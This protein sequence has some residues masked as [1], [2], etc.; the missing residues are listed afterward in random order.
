MSDFQVGDH[1]DAN[2]LHAIVR[3][4]GETSFSSGEWL[5]VELDVPE[6]KNNGSIQ[7]RKYFECEDRYGIFLRPSIARLMER[8]AAAAIRRPP[9]IISPPPANTRI[10]GRPLSLRV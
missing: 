1:V 3:F 10:G 4:V 7:G 2:G 5:G 9:P 6:G 8:P